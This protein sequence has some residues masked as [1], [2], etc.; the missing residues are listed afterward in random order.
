MRTQLQMRLERSP[1]EAVVAAPTPRAGWWLRAQGIDVTAEARTG[2]VYDRCQGVLANKLF[3]T[4]F[5]L[6]RLGDAQKNFE[7]ALAAVAVGR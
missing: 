7:K 2:L 3:L 4:G 6:S 1:A 5:G